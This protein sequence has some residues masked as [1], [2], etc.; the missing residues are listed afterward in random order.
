MA[1]ATSSSVMRSSSRG[2][3]TETR[4]AGS[5]EEALEEHVDALAMRLQVTMVDAAS[6]DQVSAV[7]D[8]AW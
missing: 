8:N 4:R 5:K 1:D 3:A 7:T 2:W 6:G